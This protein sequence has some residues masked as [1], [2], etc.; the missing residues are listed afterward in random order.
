MPPEAFVKYPTAA[1]LPADAHDRLYGSADG[2]LAW[3]PLG[4]VMLDAGPQVP[5]V[6]VMA[7]VTPPPPVGDKYPTAVQFPAD[8]QKTSLISEERAPW[9]L[10][11]CAV[12]HVPE[13][14]VAVN[15]K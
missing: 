8:E 10:T 1:Q 15:A 7:K 14:D 3:T 11:G 5:P 12:P 9:M 2:L 13:E 6:E 4:N